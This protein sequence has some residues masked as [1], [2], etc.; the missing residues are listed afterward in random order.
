MGLLHAAAC[1]QVAW[2]AAGG[3]LNDLLG[4][5][6]F[7]QGT[8]PLKWQYIKGKDDLASIARHVDY[9]RKIV[10]V[11]YKHW[12][13]KGWDW[14]STKELCKT[15]GLPPRELVPDSWYLYQK[16]YV[17]VD[18]EKMKQNPDAPKLIRLTAGGI[19]YYGELQ[20]SKFKF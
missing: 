7:K 16:G 4:R 11:L 9:R 2:A 20:K 15:L 3:V 8:P 6:L 13:E 14:I 17:A 1:L 18:E 5:D 19:D 12:E 10:H